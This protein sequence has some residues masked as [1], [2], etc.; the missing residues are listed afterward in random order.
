MH[1]ST[2]HIIPARVSAA[3]GSHRHTNN[4]ILIIKI[5]RLITKSPVLPAILFTKPPVLSTAAFMLSPVLPAVDFIIPF[6]L[7]FPFSFAVFD[8]F[9]LSVSLAFPQFQFHR[10]VFFCQTSFLYLPQGSLQQ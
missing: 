7:L 5:E 8:V 6:S 1:A 3:Q 9:F 10:P 2:V 4:I